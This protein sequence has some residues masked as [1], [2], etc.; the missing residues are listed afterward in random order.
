MFI[1]NIV[2]KEEKSR[3]TKDR[4][5]WKESVGFWWAVKL[6]KKGENNIWFI[7]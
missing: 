4:N 1:G 5:R 6:K 7:L 2:L 3:N